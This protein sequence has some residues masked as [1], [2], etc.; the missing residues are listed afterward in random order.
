MFWGS[1][2]LRGF[3]LRRE[4]SFGEASEDLERYLASDFSS[5]LIDKNSLNGCGRTFK[6]LIVVPESTTSCRVAESTALFNVDGNEIVV[7][8]RLS[9]LSLIRVFIPANNLI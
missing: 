6:R 3:K 8:N 5:T 1:W 9:N 2:P 4:H 7:W